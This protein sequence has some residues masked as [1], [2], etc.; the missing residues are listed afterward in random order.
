MGRGRRAA[1]RPGGA[2]RAPAD[3]RGGPEGGRAGQRRAGQLLHDQEVRDPGAGLHGRGRRADAQPQGQA[4]GRRGALRRNPRLLLRGPPPRSTAAAFSTGEVR[5]SRPTPP[6]GGR[7]T[8]TYS[9]TGSRPILG[10]RRTRPDPHLR[11]P[12]HPRPAPDRGLRPRGDRYGH[13]H[14]RRADRAPGRAADAP[15]ADPHRP[16][17]RARSG[18]CWTRRRCAVRSAAAPRCAPSSNTSRSWPSR[19][20]IT[21]QVLPFSSGAHVG[22]VGPITILRFAQRS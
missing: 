14:A 6:A 10:W 22:G 5:G 17:T 13:G 21:I 11:G 18:W 9:P 3:A 2:A 1:D 19:P 16:P 8:A 20:H 12:V 4:Q 7:S 15:P